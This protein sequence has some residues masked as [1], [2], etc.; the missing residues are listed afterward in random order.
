LSCC[1][2]HCR[3]LFSVHGAEVMKSWPAELDLVQ[4]CLLHWE[5][6]LRYESINCY[7]HTI[8]HIKPRGEVQFQVK[9]FFKAHYDFS[10]VASKETALVQ[11]TMH[12]FDHVT[13]KPVFFTHP[14]ALAVEQ[15]WQCTLFLIG[16]F[17]FPWPFC[18]VQGDF[19]PMSVERWDRG[20]GIPC[21]I[22]LKSF[23]HPQPW[24][25]LHPLPSPV[26]SP[27]LLSVTHTL[28]AMAYLFQ[29][30]VFKGGGKKQGTSVTYADF[31]LNAT[32]SF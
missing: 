18:K 1:K 12:C 6:I 30:V 7:F 13:G 4:I 31:T 24:P 15:I 10:T 25:F 32:T 26:T 19:P 23:F 2:C 17:D 5:N 16:R 11:S 22:M 3:K 29:S 14:Y 20:M 28:I 8:K 9:L 27:P 21:I